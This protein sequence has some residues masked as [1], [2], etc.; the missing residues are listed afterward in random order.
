MSLIASDH[1]HFVNYCKQV[2]K[3][4]KQ[5]HIQYSS[6]F[7]ADSQLLLCHMHML[8]TVSL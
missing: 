4:S 7:R 5:L 6:M 8:L 3:L 2:L 1:H